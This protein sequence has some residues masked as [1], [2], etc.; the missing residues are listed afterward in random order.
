LLESND[1]DTVE[2]QNGAPASRSAVLQ[3]DGFAGIVAMSART[4]HPRGPP[5]S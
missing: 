4:V 5:L 3:P 1:I 2:R